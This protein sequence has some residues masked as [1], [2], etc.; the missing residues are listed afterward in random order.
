MAK[1]WNRW[2]NHWETREPWQYRGE[3]DDYGWLKRSVTAILLFTVIYGAHVSDTRL[4]RAID[5]GVHYVLTVDTDWGYL[6]SQA[7]NYAPK[8]M[9]LSALK[10]VQTTVS[11]PADPLQYMS[12]PVT[13]KITAKYGW[14]QHPV[15]KQEMMH[16]GIDFAVPLGT[17]VRA[18]APG[19]VKMITDSAQFGKVLILQH[20]QAVETLYGHLGEVLVQPDD[21]V[22]Q[23]QVVAKVG[24]TGMTSGPLLYFEVRENGKAVDPLTRLKGDFPVEERK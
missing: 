10:R 11:Q 9:D 24:K 22:S 3:E 4:G 6:M 20:S 21:M 12:K 15:L 23:G 18:S 13:G 1:P 19:Q 17:S 2:Q 5:D 16:E 14:Q 8:D 7:A